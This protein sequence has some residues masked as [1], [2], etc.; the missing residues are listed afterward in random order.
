MVHPHIAVSTG[1]PNEKQVR[2]GV[3][4]PWCELVLTLA[5]DDDP[6]RSVFLTRQAGEDII[7][8]IHATIHPYIGT[9][10]CGMIEWLLDDVMDELMEGDKAN[11]E[12]ARGL[13]TAIAV[14]RNPH[15]FDVDEVRAQALQRW[16][17]RHGKEKP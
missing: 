8:S 3:I 14:L 11:K 4:P 1:M 6:A 17:I 9:S 12:Y 5:V 7:D 15:S 10:V 2:D 16:K 13:A